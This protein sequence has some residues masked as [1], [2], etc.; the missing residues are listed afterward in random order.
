MHFEIEPP[1]CV[2]REEAHEHMSR[3]AQQSQRVTELEGLLDVVK[4]KVQDLEDRCLGKAVQQHSHS[5][6]LQ[7]EKQEA[8][9]RKKMNKKK[10]KFNLTDIFQKIQIFTFHN[11]V[12]KIG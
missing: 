12:K 7:Q 4:T 3:A 5:Q 10:K 2:S 9:V 8:Q 11:D 6:Q 1:V